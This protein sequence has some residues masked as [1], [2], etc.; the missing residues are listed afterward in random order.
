MVSLN[1]FDL[2]DIDPPAHAGGT[3]IDCRL[4]AEIPSPH[5]DFRIRRQGYSS[6]WIIL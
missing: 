1:K 4:Q 5:E 2:K 6:A 3:D